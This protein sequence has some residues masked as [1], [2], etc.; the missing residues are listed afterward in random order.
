MSSDLFLK[1]YDSFVFG[2]VRAG[3]GRLLLQQYFQNIFFSDKSIHIII[4]IFFFQ[5]ELWESIRR[6]IERSRI[7]VACISKEYASSD[8]CQKEFKYTYQQVQIPIICVVV[9]N[10]EEWKNY[11]VF[12]QTK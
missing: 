2:I 8:S 5:T 9:G 12:R 10:G 4:N 11:E 1:N 7:V 3:R 6:G